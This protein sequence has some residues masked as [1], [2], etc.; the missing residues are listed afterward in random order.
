MK[1]VMTKK[2]IIKSLTELNEL[3]DALASYL[4]EK[5]GLIGFQQFSKIDQDLKK[6]HRKLKAL[7]S[8]LDEQDQLKS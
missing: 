6:G 4:T 2:E 8:E 7:L 1:R 5:K 3:E